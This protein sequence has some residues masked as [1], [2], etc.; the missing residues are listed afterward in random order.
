MFAQL[1]EIIK[2]HPTRE[3]ILLQKGTAS[4]SILLDRICHEIGGVVNFKT[5]S[6]NSLALQIATG[7]L[8]R[9]KLKL[10]PEGGGDLIIQGIL[11]DK[12]YYHHDE[13]MSGL[14]GVLWQSLAELRLAGIT[15]D[16]VRK[17]KLD[18]ATKPA[19]I[20]DLLA[21]VTDA[22]QKASLIDWAGVFELAC[23]RASN[24]PSNRLL[25]IPADLAMV[26]LEKQF[27]DKLS[28]EKTIIAFRSAKDL[29]IP[30]T[31]QNRRE[32]PLHLLGNPQAK[33][34]ALK[35]QVSAFLSPYFDAETLEVIRRIKSSQTPWEDIEI[36]VAGTSEQPAMLFSQLDTHEIAWTAAFSR[37]ITD[38]RIGRAADSLSRWAAGNFAAS[39]LLAMLEAN[40]I[41]LFPPAKGKAAKEDKPGF[42]KV[43][44]L[45]RDSHALG[46]RDGYARPLEELRKIKEEHEREIDE[47]QIVQLQKALKKVIA[48]IPEA[49]SPG[50]FASG[51]KQLF[52]QVVYPSGDLD[53]I[54][55]DQNL[56]TRVAELCDS[57]KD[58]KEPAMTRSSA[59]KWLNRLLLNLKASD[60]R[61]PAGRI[62]ITAPGS[63]GLSGRRQIYFVG[64][65]HSAIP[66]ANPVDPVLNSELRN[67]LKKIAGP[68]LVS[69]EDRR[70][71]KLARL[72]VALASLKQDAVVCLS[73]SEYEL[74]K[75]A[76]SLTPEFVKIIKRLAGDSTVRI[77]DLRGN[78][79]ILPICSYNS[80]DPQKILDIADLLRQQSRAGNAMAENILAEMSP[81][82][83]RYAQSHEQ[84]KARAA[85]LMTG[86]P[87]WD[88]VK[89]DFRKNGRA[90]STSYISS[91]TGCTF[92][93]F[94]REVL[95]CLPYDQITWQE[96]VTDRWLDHLE[97]GALLHE[98][99][100]LFLRRIDSWPVKDEHRP[101]L[102]QVTAEV[103]E[104]YRAT[105]PPP[106][107]AVFKQ[108]E[109][110]IHDDVSYFFD[111]EKGQAG[112]E[113]RPVGYEVAFG[114][115]GSSADEAQNDAARE[116]LELCFPDGSKLY[117]RGKIDRIDQGPEG[118]RI[119]DYKTGR[120]D[121]YR[122]DPEKIARAEQQMAIYMHAGE[123]LAKRG[124][125]PGKVVE[126][127]LYFPTAKGEGHRLKFALEDLARVI[128]PEDQ[129]ALFDVFKLGQFTPMVSD[130]CNFCN[131]LEICPFRQF[132]NTDVSTDEFEE[133]GEEK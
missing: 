68:T 98:I 95:R 26:G 55:H 76:A 114:M 110:R 57:L 83:A 59:M 49:G 106:D 131:A 20:A 71:E 82:Q 14:P 118:L 75:R 11:P 96:T 125:V 30:D 24:Q 32:E 108:E 117:L 38:F 128:R 36:A 34:T 29:L 70:L 54:L 122:T 86:L 87:D 12:G 61:S 100:E 21:R 107:L 19:A 99:Y 2:K 66:G 63:H 69:D 50:N 43:A 80:N 58:L 89:Y 132:G 47:K 52:K 103:I 16:Q 39:E 72:S 35:K 23:M 64:L 111:L 25:I 127:G 94:L 105:N 60:H 113:Y 9:R 67:E 81:A 42:L 123:E 33:P 51:F 40:E 13:S 48:F 115:R 112:S 101:V 121:S 8:V 85:T 78:P 6:I 44:T 79:D 124:V 119:V 22:L 90:V 91:L 56:I 102:D 31:W 17:V 104:K 130:E 120:S 27:I 45:I 73:A 126:V 62:L 65:N 93:H 88:P 41:R 3:K 77:D 7:E 4:G 28:C 1:L 97:R 10:L 74:D 15:A 116:P 46:G 92:Y 53:H 37:P 133:A 18:P 5:L 84:R 129:L 109:K